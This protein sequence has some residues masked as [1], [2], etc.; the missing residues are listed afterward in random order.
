MDNFWAHLARPFTVLAPLSGFTDRAFRQICRSYGA[1]VV[2]SEMASVAALVHSPEKA[3]ERLYFN[4]IERPYV[5]Q[6]FGA[7]PNQFGEAARLVTNRIQPDGLDINC[8]C[9]APKIIKEGAGAALG[10]DLPRARQAVQAVLSN[11]SLPVSI[12]LRA[13]NKDISAQQVVAYLADLP[14]AAVTVHGRSVSGGFSGPV[15]PGAIALCRPYVAGVLIANGG[16]VDLMT[17][18]I[19]L[20]KSLADGIMIGRGA[21]GRPWIFQEIKEGREINLTWTEL[22][23]LIRHHAQLIVAYKGEV[24][25]I[26]FRKFLAWYVKGWPQAKALRTQLMQI[27]TLS[28]LENVITSVSA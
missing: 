14:L 9:P 21:L 28:E 27:K 25:L 2:V 11:T 1:D 8:G 5:V 20:Q 4:E 26:E 24:G 22:T 16:I 18:Q 10:A 6:L 17:A 12:K 3:L 7:D 23:E 15:D 19:M 13:Q